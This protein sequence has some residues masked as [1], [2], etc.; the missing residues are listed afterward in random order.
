MGSLVGSIPTRPGFT[1]RFNTE[2]DQ[3]SLDPVSG[4]IRTLARLDREAGDLTRGD[5]RDLIVLS[6]SP[7][8]PVEVVITLT[9]INDNSPQFPNSVAQI[10]FSEGST[11]GTRA[12]LDSA[13]DVDTGNN[14]RIVEYRIQSGNEEGKFKLSFSNKPDSKV[15]YVHLETTSSL[16]REERSSFLLNITAADG[17][18]PALT[19]SML[20]TVNVLDIN[21][22]AP[23]FV[24]EEYL[25]RINE[26]APTGSFVT[27]VAAR[28][29]DTGENSRL[30]YLLAKSSL[31]DQ[32]NIDEETGVITTATLLSCPAPANICQVSVIARDHGA[33]RQDVQTKV[34]ISLI[35]ANDHD[36]QILFR[37]FPDQTAKFATV[38][39]NA[40][41]GNLVSAITVTDR[42]QGNN[43][44]TKVKI[45]QGNRAGHFR[46]DSR[47]DIHIVRVD[48]Q[49]DRETTRLYN[50]T[51]V[52]EDMGNPP[53]TS[54]AFLIIH[55]NDINDHAP[56][57]T[58]QT[59][60]AVLT[61]SSPIGSFVAAPLALDEDT[62]VNSNIYYSILQGKTVI[63]LGVLS[64]FFCSNLILSLII[65]ISAKLINF[66]VFCRK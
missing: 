13:L 38:E 51:V 19:G 46:L 65:L 32:F 56:T 20:L 64:Q 59:Y 42:D 23:V 52:A 3:F 49:L 12:L 14:G 41:A 58:E 39:E 50:L 61:E 36:P 18:R 11:P 21:D 57:F 31:A 55:V 35:D 44:K 27:Q 6:S 26:T 7:T 62:G 30:S 45:S 43:G 22:N 8:Y 53:R 5:T 34:K 29:A 2:E 1:Y 48:S 4:E 60:R 15:S 24:M 17:G 10:S 47:G 63:G 28:D 40:K 16:D 25:A 9:D 54:T 66:L 37:Y 33:P